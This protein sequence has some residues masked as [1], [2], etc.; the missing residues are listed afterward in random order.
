MTAQVLRGAGL[1]GRLRAEIDTSIADLVARG[2]RPPRLATVLAGRNAS[3]EAYRGSIVRTLEKVAIDH[4][5]VDLPGDIAR[6]E[7][8]RALDELSTD[9]AI[10]GVLVLMPLPSHLPTEIVHEHLSPLKD[11]DGITPTN[12][13][14]RTAGRSAPQPSGRIPS[15]RGQTATAR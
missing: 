13:G 5:A 15:P 1:A 10:T 11:V 2:G 9:P 8:I 3:S 4:I 12:A 7:F 14:R 6:I